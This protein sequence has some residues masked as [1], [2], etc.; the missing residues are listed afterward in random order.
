[1]KKAF[2]YATVFVTGMSVM[3]VE[4][5]ASRLMAPYFGTSLFVWTN[6][7]GIVLVAMSIGY[8]LGGRIADRNDGKTAKK[9]LYPLILITGFLIGIIPFIGQPIFLMAYQ[10]IPG[11]HIQ[12]FF[13]SLIAS[14]GLFSIPLLFLAMVTP[15]CA[16]IAIEK[17]NTAGSTVGSIYAFSTVGSIVGTFLP[18]L[19]TIPFLG[20]R[21]TFFLF[22]AILMLL[23]LIGIGRAILFGFMIIP[24][25]LFF[26]PLTIHASP[27]TEF[28]GESV[29]NYMRVQKSTF[30][31][32]TLHTNKDISVVQSMYNPYRV[33]TGYYWDYATLLPVLNPQGK[34]FL[35]IGLAGGTSARILHNF[36]P[37]LNIEGVEID[38]LMVEVGKKYFATA[39]STSKITESDGRMFL[40]NSD[41]KYDFVM[42]DA[43][44]DDLYIPAHLTTS[45]FFETVKSHLTANGSVMMNIASSE[46]SELLNLI[47]N[48]LTS[49]FDNVYEFRSP[50]SDNSVLFAFNV[51]PDFNPINTAA[52]RM[53][54]R[55]VILKILRDIEKIEYSDKFSI[56]TDNK[57]PIEFLTEKMVLSTHE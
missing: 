15:I 27:N 37:N 33:M 6:V 48:T 51:A 32:R 19:L 42:I 8:W 13:A 12:I 40:A 57:S 7:I 10:A 25:V 46:N 11:Q 30:G 24:I 38:P 54:I 23:G 29:Y 50:A 4:L 1:M 16:R 47:K 41:K 31:T 21:E 9:L 55:A 22:G 14:I 36:F 17:I 53:D 43:Y 26:I 5:T 18:V 28:E 56:S 45:E 2:L 20:S 44:K 52:L 35:I 3:A 34:D 49:V 39:E